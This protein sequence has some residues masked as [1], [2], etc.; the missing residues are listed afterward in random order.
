MAET[1]S[2][3]VTNYSDI[4]CLIRCVEEK[5]HVTSASGSSSGSIDNSSSRSRS[6]ASKLNTEVEAHGAVFGGSAKFGM[7]SSESSSDANSRASKQAS[8]HSVEMSHSGF[9]QEGYV[10]VLP[11]KKR[12]FSVKANSWYISVAMVSGGKTGRVEMPIHNWSMAGEKQLAFVQSGCGRYDL[13]HARH[14]MTKAAKAEQYVIESVQT[15]HCLHLEADLQD[16]ASHIVARDQRAIDNGIHQLIAT[17]AGYFNAGSDEHRLI[18]YFNVSVGGNCWEIEDS[19]PKQGAKLVVNGALTRYSSHFA[20]ESVPTKVNEDPANE[21]EEADDFRT[22]L[23][24]WGLGKFAGAM[25]ENGYDDPQFWHEITEEEL[26]DDMGMKKGHLKKWDAQMQKYQDRELL[27]SKQPPTKPKDGVPE[28]KDPESDEFVQ[29][30]MPRESDNQFRIRVRHSKLCLEIVGSAVVQSEWKGNLSQRFVLRPMG[31][32]ENSGVMPESEV[33][34]QSLFSWSGGDCVKN[35]CIGRVDVPSDY[36]VEF[37]FVIN[38]KTDSWSSILH[39]GESREQPSPGFLIYPNEMKLHVRMSDA[40][41]NQAYDPPIQLEFHTTYR[42][43]L[44]CIGGTRKLFFDG[45]KIFIQSRNQEHLTRVNA[46]IWISDPWHDAADA[47]V[48]NLEIYVPKEVDG[49]DE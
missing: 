16:R 27:P 12:E 36:V 6:K 2:V 49:K 42:V 28:Q 26:T 5:K 39:I 48:S 40:N 20:F 43:K 10:Q 24:K 4:I 15:G 45:Q 21:P 41:S 31:H 37:D 13:V 18:G 1:T 47:V 9:V 44:E 7:E 25:E 14:V 30:Y 32:I 33:S 38:T 8:A 22:V 35:E 46:P 17:D 3:F 19:S 11:F 34:D 23:N 29:Q